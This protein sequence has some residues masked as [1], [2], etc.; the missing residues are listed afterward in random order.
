MSMSGVAESLVS[1]DRGAEAIPILDEILR[2]ASGRAGDPSLVPDVVALRSR[3]FAKTRDVAGC[4][5]TAEMWEKLGRTDADSL[6]NAACFRAVTAGVILGSKGSASEA[7]AEADR[8]ITWL[9]QSVTAG[10]RAATMKKDKEL[11]A[12]RGR[13]DFKSLLAE[14]ERRAEKAPE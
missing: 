10:F 12:L 13:D 9:R 14:V 6:Y 5:T 11:D 4:R 3:Y 1:L 8:A 7:S 2:R